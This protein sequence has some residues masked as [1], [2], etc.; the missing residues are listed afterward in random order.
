VI[1]D[2]LHFGG[3]ARD[4]VMAWVDVPS[5]ALTRSEQRY[6]PLRPGRVRFRSGAFTADVEFDG[7]GFVVLYPGLAERLT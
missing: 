3:A 5:L 6:E 7:D 4:Y 1:R 2:R